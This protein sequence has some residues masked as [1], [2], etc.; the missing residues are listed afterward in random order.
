VGDEGFEPPDILRVKQVLSRPGGLAEFV[1]AETPPGCG[2]TGRPQKT[3]RLGWPTLFDESIWEGELPWN[4]S[5]FVER[6]EKLRAVMS[7]AER[8]FQVAREHAAERN[9]ERSCSKCR[10]EG[11]D[12]PRGIESRNGKVISAPFPF[13][14][15][16]RAWRGRYFRGEVVKK[17][18]KPSHRH[19][20]ICVTH[21]PGAGCNISSH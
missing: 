5:V 15:A 13:Q 3:C 1:V 7:G 12:G 9:D 18:R 14:L 11:L 6:R 16:L 2:H 10:S 4:I 8:P 21:Y 17:S 19:E 20:S